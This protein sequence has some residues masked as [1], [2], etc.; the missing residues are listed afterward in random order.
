MQKKTPQHRNAIPQENVNIFA[1]GFLYCL[2]EILYSCAQFFC[3]CLLLGETM[4]HRR[5][6]LIF[7]NQQ[8]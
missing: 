4:Q 7:A 1:P 3:I 2:A 5:Q 6:S 8:L